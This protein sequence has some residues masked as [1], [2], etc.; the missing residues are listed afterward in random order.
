MG[1]TGSATLSERDQPTL[2]HVLRH[3][4]QSAAG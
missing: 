1:R 2:R 3:A 4:P